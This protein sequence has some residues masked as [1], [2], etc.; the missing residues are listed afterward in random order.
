M[1]IRSD[2]FYKLNC[3]CS[4]NKS[5]PPI[6]RNRKKTYAGSYK[7]N[8]RSRYSHHRS[9]LIKR[10]PLS[11]YGFS[12]PTAHNVQCRGKL[13]DKYAKHEWIRMLQFISNWKI[14]HSLLDPTISP[15]YIIPDSKLLWNTST[16]TNFLCLLYESLLIMNSND[17]ELHKYWFSYFS[18]LYFRFNIYLTTTFT[19]LLEIF[20]M[21]FFFWY[22]RDL[23]S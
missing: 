3:L 17:K 14:L 2:L 10:K 8:F 11:M 23:G 5:I 22:K 19:I 15:L 12:W 1:P 7:S 20:Y 21:C 13:Y 6:Y 4:R 16:G 18:I 9:S